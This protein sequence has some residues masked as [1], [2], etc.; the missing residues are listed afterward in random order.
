M[1]RGVRGS[2]ARG[3]STDPTN[4]TGEK[5]KSMKLGGGKKT[6]GKREFPHPKQLSYPV[7]LSPDENNGSRLLIKCFQ[8]YSHL[9][10]K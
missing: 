8:Y 7:A 3:Q 4:N 10:L 5:I 6:A 9:F 1:V 2:G